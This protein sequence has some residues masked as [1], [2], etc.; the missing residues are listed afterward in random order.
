[1]AGLLPAFSVNLKLIFMIFIIHQEIIQGNVCELLI[2]INTMTPDN[3]LA[4]MVLTLCFKKGDSLVLL[5]GDSLML[6]GCAGNSAESGC[7]LTREGG[8]RKE[9]QKENKKIIK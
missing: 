7:V 6:P 9:A 2:E 5:K 8:R 1:M 4:S 3:V